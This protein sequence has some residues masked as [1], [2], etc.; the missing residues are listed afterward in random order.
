[1]ERDYII[2]CGDEYLVWVEAGAAPDAAA[3]KR[4]RVYARLGKTAPWNEADEHR[5]AWVGSGFGHSRFTWQKARDIV[6]NKLKSLTH[7]P[8]GHP[9][10]KPLTDRWRYKLVRI[11]PKGDTIRPADKRGR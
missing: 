6:W 9:H 11:V 7:G 5:W 8:F 10:P 4:E 3:Q 2:K 1:M